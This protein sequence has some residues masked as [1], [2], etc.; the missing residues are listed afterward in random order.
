MSIKKDKPAYVLWY[1]GLLL[2][3]QV[4]SYESLLVH[5]CFDVCLRQSQFNVDYFGLFYII[6]VGVTNG[7]AHQKASQNTTKIVHIIHKDSLLKFAFLFHSFQTLCGCFPRFQFVTTTQ[8]APFVRT[9]FP[10]HF[11]VK[12]NVNL[13]L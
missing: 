11:F 3:F 2:L 13:S 10:T 12:F 7:Y 4:L 8:A 1:A 6:H 9:F 5:D